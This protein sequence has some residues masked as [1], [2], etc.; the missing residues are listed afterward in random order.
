MEVEMF[1]Q[2]SGCRAL[3]VNRTS[4]CKSWDGVMLIA[5]LK[6]GKD[7]LRDGY[8]GEYATIEEARQHALK[9]AFELA[10]NRP[11]QI[12]AGIISAS[13]R[14]GALGPFPDPCGRSS[15]QANLRLL[16]HELLLAFLRGHV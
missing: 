11:S 4:R 9:V 15:V 3:S 6:D 10:R 13:D 2:L 12:G 7:V 1:R 16:A 5:D 8:G 14:R